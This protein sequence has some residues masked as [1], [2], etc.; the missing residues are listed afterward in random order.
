ML[1]ITARNNNETPLN[2]AS[3]FY[4]LV[5]LT[6][7]FHIFSIYKRR[8]GTLLFARAPQARKRM[9]IE[10]EDQIEIRIAHSLPRNPTGSEIDGLSNLHTTAANKMPDTFY[11]VRA[12]GTIG[13]LTPRFPPQTSVDRRK[14]RAPEGWF[15]RWKRRRAGSDRGFGPLGIR[16]GLDCIS[17]HTPTVSLILLLRARERLDYAEKDFHVTISSVLIRIIR[18]YLRNANTSNRSGRAP[19]S[20]RL[21]KS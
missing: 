13:A 16:R 18:K 15:P 20:C 21:W 3:L 9:S 11:L 2:F 4:L 12:N 17:W 5:P 14:R 8:D 10:C 6:S 19:S 1:L 7:E